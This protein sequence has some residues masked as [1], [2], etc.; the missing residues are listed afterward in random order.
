MTHS[1]HSVEK[2]SIHQFDNW[3]CMLKD[4]MLR[5]VSDISLLFLTAWDIST[6]LRSLLKPAW[7]MVWWREMTTLISFN[8]Y[9]IFSVQ[10]KNSIYCLFVCLQTK[11]LNTPWK[12]KHLLTG[13]Q[14]FDISSK[15]RQMLKY[16]Q[17]PKKYNFLLFHCQA[18]ASRGW[19][20]EWN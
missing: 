2:C 6:V 4:M 7:N 18:S 11:I 20:Q 8:A 15:S 14:C 13:K 12:C 1:R 19:Q 17:P 3:I 9:S 10:Y 5:Y 16:T